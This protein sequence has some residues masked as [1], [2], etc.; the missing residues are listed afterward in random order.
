M[1]LK[2]KRSCGFTLAE[3][4]VALC[5]VAILT[6][7]A[8]PGFKKTMRDLKF[9]EFVCNFESL[10]KVFRSYYLIFNEW[11]ADGNTNI[12]PSGN[13]RYLLPNHLYRENQFIYRPLRKSG[14]SFDFE[15][16]ITGNIYSDDGVLLRIA[17][18][19]RIGDKTNATLCF[20]RL[21]DLDDFKNHLY[22]H[23]STCV[24]YRVP[25]AAHNTCTE[26]RYY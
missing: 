15:N 25:E 21:T 26:N 22:Y 8:V 9:N 18:D 16:W 19:A 17:V 4:M 1:R 2:H 13:I 23:C 20:N 11:P 12:V 7:V 10:I 5:I 24:I 3:I 6:A 14:A